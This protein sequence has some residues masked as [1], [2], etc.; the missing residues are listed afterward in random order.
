VTLI[1][2]IQVR[3][4]E[5]FL[6]GWLANIAP[7]V[8]AIIALDD[9]STDA[10]AEILR[11]HPKLIELLSNPPGQPWDERR[12]QMAL[13]HAGRRHAATWFLCTDADHRMERAFATRV[14]DLLHRAD[15]ENIHIFSFQLRELWGD[16]RHYR[17]DGD[18]NTAIRYRLFRNDPSHRRF[19]PRPLHRY[20][21]P[22]ELASSLETSGRHT[23]LN[24]YHL[25]MIAS[26]DRAARMA[27][28]EAMDP[29]AIYESKKTYRYLVDETGLQRTEIPPERDFLPA[30]D[31]AIPPPAD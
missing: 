17:S 4:E 13:L 6:P 14:G 29:Q 26:A 31:P 16:R 21:F 18:W 25:R 19:D 7:S 30:D 20:W 10:T 1:A 22:L 27:R 28:Y 3:N 9:G 5:R 24:I 8:D 23:E 2:L 11:V 12:N 15:A